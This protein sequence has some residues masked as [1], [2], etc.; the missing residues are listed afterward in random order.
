MHILSSTSNQ[1]RREAAAILACQTLK[2]RV[3][4]IAT[5]FLSMVV[6]AGLA[7]ALSPNFRPPSWVPL[8]PA[9]ASEPQTSIDN[10]RLHMSH[11]QACRPVCGEVQMVSIILVSGQLS[12]DTQAAKPFLVYETVRKTAHPQSLSILTVVWSLEWLLSSV[13]ALPVFQEMCWL[14]RRFRYSILWIRD[15]AAHYSFLRCRQLSGRIHI[16]SSH[17]LFVEKRLHCWNRERRR[18]NHTLRATLIWSS[19]QVN[20]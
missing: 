16:S 3:M 12:A 13:Q 8:A 2:D 11:S 9:D 17:Y 10:P 19:Y 20:R 18:T 4:R 7:E 6:H 5:A 14:I 1:T 15:R